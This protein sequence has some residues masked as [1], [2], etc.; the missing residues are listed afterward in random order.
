MDPAS[1]DVRPQVVG[2]RGVAWATK[3][4]LLRCGDVRRQDAAAC[5]WSLRSRR[6]AAPGWS[7]R[8]CGSI[9]GSPWI[10][11]G[12][13]AL[14]AYGFVATL[15]DDANFGRILAAYGGI[16][17]AG[18]L[19]W[20]VVVDGFRPDRFDLIGAAICLV[21]VGGD[22]VRPSLKKP[23]DLRLR[24]NLYGAG[25][26][27]LH[28]R[29]GRRTQ[30]V[31]RVGAA[32]LRG[33]RPRR[34]RR[35][36]PAP[37]TASTT[38]TA[39][40]AWRSSPGPSS[41]AA[42]SR[43]SPTSSTSGTA[44]AAGRCSGGSTTSSPTKIA[45]A[46]R[47]IAELTALA[48]Q[49]HHAAAQLAGPAIDGP[50]ATQCACLALDGALAPVTLTT[51]EPAMS[52]PTR[53]AS[54]PRP[55]RRRL[56]RL[57]RRP[58]PCVPRRAQHRRARQHLAHRRRRPAHRR[59]AERVPRSGA[60][61]S[62]V[63]EPTRAVAVGPRPVESPA[64]PRPASHSAIT[65]PIGGHH[66]ADPHLRRHRADRLHRQQRR[67]PGAHRSGRTHADPPRPARTHRHGLLLHFP[68][69]PDIDADLRGFTVD[70]KRCCTFWGFDVTAPTA[71]SSP[72]AGTGP[73]RSTTS[74]TSS[75]CSSTATSPSPPSTASSDAA[76]LLHDRRP[77]DL[78]SQRA[79]WQVSP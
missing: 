55:R 8:A 31:Q 13:A 32:L 24:S 60:A 20:G 4:F 22:H 26:E 63:C 69:S 17:V 75:S 53:T 73:P 9:A 16:F 42:R 49:L 59:G 38:T 7:G 56:R 1:G 71:T 62:R 3:G 19:A 21:G 72:S 25:H 74:S 27:H 45:D 23:L 28:D 76:P 47:Q 41:S 39:L 48:D 37:A 46:E 29:R 65:P 14:A 50:C 34:A 12:I 2:G 43:R 36:G 18:S 15:Q 78:N 68:K 57:L 40:P 52:R 51:K 54:H 61:G 6:S 70:E 35:P 5:S 67:D 33:H 64:H 66:E 30:R 11:A 79:P 44:S 58:D 10:G 77:R